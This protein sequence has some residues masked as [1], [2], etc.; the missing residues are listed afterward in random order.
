MKPPSTT[1]TLGCFCH[2]TMLTKSMARSK[3]T[4]GGDGWPFDSKKPSRTRVRSWKHQSLLL[5][6]VKLRRIVGVVH[7]TK[8]KQNLR[9]FCKLMN[10]QECVWEIRYRKITKTI[11][12]E[13]VRVHYSTTIW[14]TNL[15]LCL[16]SYENSSSESSGGQGMEKLEKIS[17]WNLTKVKSKKDV[18]DE[19]R[20]S[21]ATVHFASLMDMS[22]KKC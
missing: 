17:A 1:T 5:C 3:R 16:K 18:I 7:P 22:S 11:L 8:F 6:P 2:H 12:Q 14:F 4:T 9:V 19:A 15:F 10:P 21:G 13:K 20:T